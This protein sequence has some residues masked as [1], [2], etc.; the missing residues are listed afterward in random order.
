[1]T[2][3]PNLEIDQFIQ[4]ESAYRYQYDPAVTKLLT[5]YQLEGRYK[6]RE[7]ARLTV[8]G[9]I[10][11]DPI[12]DIQPLS[13][14]SPFGDRF[15]P[16]APRPTFV[17]HFY[18]RVREAYVDLFFS[19]LDLRI[20]EQI[21]RWGVIE[22]FRITDE[23]NPLDFSEFLL[24]EVTDRYIPV[25]MVKADFYQGDTTWE[26]VWI[27]QLIFNRPA[28]PGSEWV[29]FQ[30]PPNLKNPPERFINSNAGIRVTRQIAGWDLG[31]SYL[32]AWDSFPS[33]SESIFGLSGISSHQAS[34]F[35][36]SYH[37]IHTLGVSFSKGIEGN[38]LKMEAAYV[39]GKF[40]GTNAFL[41]NTTNTSDVFELRRNYLKYA[42]GW[43]T[44]VFGVDTFIQFSQQRIFDWDP[45][46]LQGRVQNGLSFL[47]QK[48]LLYDRL[49]LKM[50]ILYMPDS[51]EAMIR[52]RMEYRFTD[53]LKGAM[54]VDLFEGT[55]G[56]LSGPGTFHFI[57]YFNLNNR[58]YSELRYSF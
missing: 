56:S 23:L 40:F 13:V 33:A 34:R 12:Y 16:T 15:D 42:F 35:T 49:I 29:E 48:N 47:F 37:R 10:A 55:L 1:M 31:G 53:R 2:L 57:G 21:A 25:A 58:V 50:L 26:G 51:R 7:W 43:D 4:N 11:Y 32:Y 38:V 22:G 39:I 20:G 18:P 30:L 36:P 54:G 46:I 3:P 41:P 14:T 45:T 19:K 24:R 27:P 8:T 52:P 28:P 6:I 9:R 44:K 5:F 17:K